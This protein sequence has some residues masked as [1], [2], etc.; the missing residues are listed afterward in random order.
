MGPTRGASYRGARDGLY[1]NAERACSAAQRQIWV[2]RGVCYAAKQEGTLQ[3]LI[4]SILK[5]H[6]KS[7]F[8]IYLYSFTPKEDKYTEIAKTSGCIF[9]DIKGLTDIE[10]V[11]LARKD[12]LD[13]AIDLMGY[14]QYNRMSI[15]SY[16]VAPIQ[17]NYLGYPGS[18]G[19]DTIDYI[20][21]DKIIIPDGYEK[22]ITQSLINDDLNLYKSE[23][24]ENLGNEP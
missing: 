8:K 22:F 6:D 3:Y 21:A 24:Q 20:L 17:I 19:S 2:L 7:R 4:A 18:L 10:A 13:I 12:R 1:N 9:K 15:F 5:L 14:I 23:L 11:E 16:R